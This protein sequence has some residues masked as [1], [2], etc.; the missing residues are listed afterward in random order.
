MHDSA[1]AAKLRNGLLT[2]QII[3]ARMGETDRYQRGGRERFTMAGWTL[4]R[5]VIDCPLF[6]HVEAAP[7]WFGQVRPMMAGAKE[8]IWFEVRDD[9]ARI[10]AHLFYFR[11]SVGVQGR[12]PSAHAALLPRFTAERVMG[13]VENWPVGFAVKDAGHLVRR[14]GEHDELIRGDFTT[15]SAWLA[16]L[17]RRRA[18]DVEDAA[19]ANAWLSE[20]APMHHDELMYWGAE[21]LGILGS[22][23]PAKAE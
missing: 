5:P 22:A 11:G 7:P 10:R 16:A 9:R 1:L 2:G 6:L 12:T 14:F 8:P 20:R 3:P 19:A 18:E 15:G 23:S 17:D 4:G 21:D 13:T